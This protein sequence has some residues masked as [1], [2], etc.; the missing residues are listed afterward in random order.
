MIQLKGQGNDEGAIYF[1]PPGVTIEK[2]SPVRKRESGQKPYFSKV[3]EVIERVLE[4]RNEIEAKAADAYVVLV[5]DKS[6][7]ST[8]QTCITQKRR[9]RPQ[10]LDVEWKNKRKHFMKSS[11]R[12]GP[13]YQVAAIPAAGSF[14]SSTSNVYDGSSL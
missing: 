3:R 5:Q 4:K 7:E 2:E 6:D 8:V 1:L 12:I 10:C 9:T 14:I 13:D 11:S